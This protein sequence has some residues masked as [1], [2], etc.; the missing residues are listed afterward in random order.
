MSLLSD[1][2]TLLSPLGIPLETGV[3][4]DT[5]PDKY[6]V[7]VPLTDSFELHA[8]NNPEY[9]IQEVRISLYEKG[10]YTQD[11][12]SIVSALLDAEITITDR[13]YI[14]YDGDTGYHHY[15]IDTANLYETED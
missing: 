13:R 5:A 10:S 7:F 1:L 2:N 15:V 8:D 3:F 11:K 14:G 9:D 4:T 6:L 12:N